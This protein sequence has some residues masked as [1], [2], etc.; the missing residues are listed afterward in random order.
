M[1]KASEYRLHAEE[2]RT[3]AS[4]M[5]GEQREQLLEMARTWD[6]LAQER[7]DLVRRHPELG[8]RGEHQEETIST[9]NE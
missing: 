4:Q 9:R 1:K 3:L 5:K 7:S 6:Q 8:L 2:C